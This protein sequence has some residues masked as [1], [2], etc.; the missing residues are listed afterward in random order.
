MKAHDLFQC[1]FTA[2]G[3]CMWDWVTICVHVMSPVE[4]CA[5]DT[6]ETVVRKQFHGPQDVRIILAARDT[7]ARG[8]NLV[9][10]LISNGSF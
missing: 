8:I 10:D 6:V 5:L 7:G 4:E 2:V 3:Q 1:V 9:S